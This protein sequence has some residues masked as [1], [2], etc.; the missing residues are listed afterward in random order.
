MMTGCA[1]QTVPYQAPILPANLT[2]PCPPLAA[3]DSGTGAA[4]LGKLVEVA[5]MYRDCA[6]AHAALI[7]ATK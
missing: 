6:A 4:V 1:S 7:D 5:G 2:Q 3:L